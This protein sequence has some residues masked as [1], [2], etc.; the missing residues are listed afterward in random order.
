M[1][2]QGPG[3][4]LIQF[5]DFTVTGRDF[6]FNDRHCEPSK[7][8]NRIGRRRMLSI[9]SACSRS[10]LAAIETKISSPTTRK[11]PMMTHPMIFH[12]IAD[13][14]QLSQRSS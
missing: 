6:L 9:C 10:Y 7:N 1:G 12:V 8:P 13:E 11:I 14:K 4:E 2:V 3:K 5:E